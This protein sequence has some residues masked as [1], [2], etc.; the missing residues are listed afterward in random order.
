[1]N[2]LELLAVLLLSLALSFSSVLSANAQGNGGISNPAPHAS[3]LLDLTSADKG[4]A[5]DAH[6]HRATLRQPAP[7]TGLVVFDTT[8]NSFWYF[9][10]TL[11]AARNRRRIQ[12]GPPP[13]RHK[14][15]IRTSS[16]PRTTFHSA[17]G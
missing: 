3:A 12:V 8:T 15:C 11:G 9:D 1:M 5:D 14:R 6:D 2:A 10:G 13:A 4:L 16:A 17:F 7:A